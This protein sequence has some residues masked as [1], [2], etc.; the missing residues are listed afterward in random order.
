MTQTSNPT[1]TDVHDMVVVH[2]VFRRE[3]R[4][5]PQLVREVAPGD[6]ARARVLAG[7]ARL[8]L[9]GLEGHHTSEDELLWPKLLER[10]T[11]DAELVHR[12]E[13]QH[14]RV[15]DALE[16]LGPALDRW[17]AGARPAVSE[18]VAAGFD[19]LRTALLEHLDDEEREILPLA[20]R[21]I[22]QAEWNE[23]GEHGAKKTTFSEMPILFGAVAEE[24]TPEEMVHILSTVPAPVRF[25][26]RTVFAKQY[27]R[28]ISRVRTGR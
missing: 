1:L 15:H 23:L 16:D 27:A 18:E 7:H 8:V 19:A 10:C 13:A 24:A 17:E 9:R 21:H 26:L 22:D 25:L 6:T 3:L 28:Y 2:R 5:I 4:L 20:A 14:E 12:M 11:P